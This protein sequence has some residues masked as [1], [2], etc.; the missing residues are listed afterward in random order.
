MRLA[1]RFSSSSSANSRLM[2]IESRAWP[3]TVVNTWASTM[4]PPATVQA[5][6]TV[7]EHTSGKAT[8][9]LDTNSANSRSAAER[10][11]AAN[12]SNGAGDVQQRFAPN[13]SSGAEDMQPKTEAP[14]A[15]L[16]F[17][18]R[19]TSPATPAAATTAAPA[20]QPSSNA[21]VQPAVSRAPAATAANPVQPS[22]PVQPAQQNSN[23]SG[24][25]DANR[26]PKEREVSAAKTEPAAPASTLPAASTSTVIAATASTPAPTIS[27]APVKEATPVAHTPQANELAEKPAAAPA[28]RISLSLSDADN[29]RVEV[30]L[31]E[32]G[33][34]VRV[35]VRSA[36]EALSHSMRA[37]LGSL[38][39]K[40]SQS[41][42]SAESYAPTGANTSGFSNQRQSSEERDSTAGG[43]Q[44]PQQGQSGGQ[45]QP[46][47]EGRGQRPAWV[48][49]LENSLS[50]KAAMR[51][52]QPWQRA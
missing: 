2:E 10:G 17:A 28:Q 14:A 45:Q 25:Q 1:R 46:S 49:E 4:L 31:M 24:A 21:Q 12:N 48:E 34:E 42:Y 18:L 30:H 22:A 27:Q 15:N 35:S 39:G 41:G 51:S 43:R 36:D 44:N 20:T 9:S 40:L 7:V 19:M 32:R 26:N 37:D 33:G 13:N 50:S 52:N 6:G 8:L 23:Q 38:N 11:L 16:A 47:R 29:Q 5:T 3:S